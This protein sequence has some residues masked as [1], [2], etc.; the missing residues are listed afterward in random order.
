MKPI[1]V[2]KKQIIV[3]VTL[4]G[5]YNTA[6]PLTFILDTGFDG[7]LAILER[8]LSLLRHSQAPPIGY[9]AANGRTRPV[10]SY[11][12]YIHGGEDNV[13]RHAVKS[14]MDQ[15]L[16]GMEFLTG[17]RVLFEAWENGKVAIKGEHSCRWMEKLDDLMKSCE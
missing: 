3:E 14:H 7:E 17:K 15:N 5:K 16:I 2:V 12:V 6:V 1:G 8:D 10:D 13:P 4:V 11:H 9:R